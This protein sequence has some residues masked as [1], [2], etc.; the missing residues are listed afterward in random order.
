[1]LSPFALP[2]GLPAVVGMALVDLKTAGLT[3]RRKDAKKS[4]AGR[5]FALSLPFLASLRLCVSLLSLLLS[6]F[7]APWR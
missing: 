7:V 2:A 4:E 5:V 6:L 1:L 3:Q